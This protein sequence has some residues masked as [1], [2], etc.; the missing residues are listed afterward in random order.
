MLLLGRRMTLLASAR[1]TIT[2]W[3]ASLTFS[4]LHWRTRADQ[5]GLVKRYTPYLHANIV[6]RLEGTCRVR[7]RFGLDT[8]CCQ[9]QML[10]ELDEERYKVSHRDENDPGRARL[11]VIGFKSAIVEGRVLGLVDV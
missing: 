7:D 3:F 9:L 11:T 8:E 10:R 6:I 4:R 5:Q 2:T 1:S